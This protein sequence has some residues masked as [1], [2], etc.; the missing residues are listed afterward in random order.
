MEKALVDGFPTATDL[1]D[2]LVRVL[3]MPFRRAHHATGRIVALAEQRKCSL[4]DLPLDAMQ[5][6]ESGI[7]NDIYSVLSNAASVDSRT[8]F[9]GTAPVRV[10]EAVK[11]AKERY[12]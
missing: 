7:S 12:L 5:Q 8:S 3:G 6:V 1:A 11:A 4:A 9:G 10:R 2:W